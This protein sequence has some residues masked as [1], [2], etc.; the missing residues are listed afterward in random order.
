MAAGLQAF[1][2]LEQL[3][4]QAG[5]DCYL[6]VGSMSRAGYDQMTE[7][8]TKQQTEEAYLFLATYGGDPD[9]GY[10]IARALRHH[11]RHLT[12]VIPT[13][14]KSAG[15]LLAIGADQLVISDK[16][17]LGPLDM[18]LKKPDELFDM[19]SGLDITQAMAFLRTQSADILKSTLVEL[20]VD[21]EVTTKTAA[22]IATKLAQGLVSPIYA[23][24]DP[25]KIGESQR[26]ISIAFSYGKRLDEKVKNLK[27]EAALKSLV[28][29]YPSHGFVIDRKEATS[30][31]KNVRAP[32]EWEQAVVESLYEVCNNPAQRPP[33]TFLI[34]AQTPNEGNE[35]VSVEPGQEDRDGQTAGDAYAADDGPA[36]PHE[37]TVEGPGQVGEPVPDPEGD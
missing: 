6:Y 12:L 20:K 34:Q 7:W 17:E 35:N 5:K 22:E 32:D 19:S 21:L 16:G 26:A 4:R 13:F 24:I 27:G 8:F 10:R 9:A 31:F 28:L 1:A 36:E 2:R 25:Y 33:F 18:Q 3:S 14:C 37:R 29:D 23:Q 15:T 11:Y 30:L